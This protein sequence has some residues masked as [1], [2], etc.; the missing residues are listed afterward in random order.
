MDPFVCVYSAVNFSIRVTLRRPMVGTAP[1]PQRTPCAH[2]CTPVPP[3]SFYIPTSS[4]CDTACGL[5]RLTVF[6]R[7]V[8][9]LRAVEVAACCGGPFLLD[10][11]RLVDIWSF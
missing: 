2:S 5:R 6:T 4:V 11:F 9:P 7:S 8:V 10:A 3:V 1:S